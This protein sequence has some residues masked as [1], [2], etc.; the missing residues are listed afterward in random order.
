MGALSKGIAGSTRTPTGASP[1]R[2][3]AQLVA[4]PDGVFRWVAGEAR[5]QRKSKR[6]GK[7]VRRLSR[8]IRITGA[9]QRTSDQVRENAGWRCT[10]DGTV[11]T[12]GYSCPN[13]SGRVDSGPRAPGASGDSWNLT[14]M[15]IISRRYKKTRYM[16]SNGLAGCR[17]CADWFTRHPNEF[18]AFAV[19]KIG[20][21]AYYD[22]Y[23]LAHSGKGG[24]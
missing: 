18:L 22:L 11:G 7:P 21:R 4:L 14:N 13:R 1:R 2:L 23:T 3:I 15:H 20:Q 19:A 24:A 8:S 16:A 12:F 5:K 10:N 17:P 6:T 9:D